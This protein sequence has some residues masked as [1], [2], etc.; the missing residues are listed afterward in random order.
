MLEE[1]PLHL[2]TPSYFWSTDP[3]LVD[4]IFESTQICTLEMIVHNQCH[5]SLSHKLTI[6]YVDFVH[7]IHLLLQFRNLLSMQWHIFIQIYKLLVAP[8]L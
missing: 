7:V 6:E 5:P 1:L 2:T 4:S 3:I 8:I